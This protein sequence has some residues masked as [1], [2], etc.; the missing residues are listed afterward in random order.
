M[1][2]ETWG[3]DGGSNEEGGKEAVL[4]GRRMRNVCEFLNVLLVSP[5]V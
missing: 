5:S 4:L 2:V 3:E 1:K